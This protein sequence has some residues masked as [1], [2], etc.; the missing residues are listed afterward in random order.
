MQEQESFSDVRAG[1]RGGA[2]V[3]FDFRPDFFETAFVT[4]KGGSRASTPRSSG[5]TGGR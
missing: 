5:S 1:S 3:V 4:T 2:A